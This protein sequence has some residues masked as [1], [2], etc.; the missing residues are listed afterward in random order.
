VTHIAGDFLTLHRTFTGFRHK[1]GS[2]T[3]EMVRT[4]NK[5]LGQMVNELSKFRSKG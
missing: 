4:P 3:N 2:W 1:H 5:A